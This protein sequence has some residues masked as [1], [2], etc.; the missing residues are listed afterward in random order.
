M[1]ARRWWHT[2]LIP[3]LRRQRRADLCEF[4]VSLLYKVSSRSARAVT[5]R[6]LVSKNKTNKKKERKKERKRER[7]KERKSS[8]IFAY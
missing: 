4:K 1:R 8:M 3:V 5:Q 2:P 7:K 6:D